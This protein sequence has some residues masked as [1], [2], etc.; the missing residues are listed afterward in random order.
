MQ[1]QEE[2]AV[3]AT[4]LDGHPSGQ[5]YY[6]RT[7]ITGEPQDLPLPHLGSR[8]GEV[9]VQPHL[10]AFCGVGPYGDLAQ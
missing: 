9:T 2:G 6:L 8:C 10:V 5:T 3:G 7:G 4:V 1:E